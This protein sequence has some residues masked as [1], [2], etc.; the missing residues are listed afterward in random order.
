MRDDE[1]RVFMMSRC[2]GLVFALLAAG[3]ATSS[4]STRVTRAPAVALDPSK[5]IR[6]DVRM[7]CHD[8]WIGPSADEAAA[9]DRALAARPQDPKLRIPRAKR[10]KSCK[11][12]GWARK[13]TEMLTGAIEAELRELGYRIERKRGK[14]SVLY[15]DVRLYR[16]REIDEPEGSLVGGASMCTGGC[17]GRPCR[18]IDQGGYVSAKIGLSN[19]GRRAPGAIVYPVELKVYGSGM[20]FVETPARRVGSLT[21]PA[22]VQHATRRRLPMCSLRERRQAM[23]DERQHDW[24][25]AASMLPGE[26]AKQLPRTFAPYEETY[27]VELFE[28]ETAPN[29]AGFEAVAGGDWK[30]AL[31]A[32][33]LDRKQWVADGENDDREQAARL[34]NVAAA[35]MV[36]GQLGPARKT[37]IAGLRLTSLP[38][39]HDLADEIVRRIADSKKLRGR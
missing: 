18:E 39:S 21:L 38:A 25:H 29:R 26:L 28:S 19:T 16:I 3:C 23:H 34:H 36:L 1:P 27:R 33:E 24:D 2:L 4:F 32:F 14:S 31:D 22:I 37:I 30:R 10:E 11:G 7:V 17:G 8:F 20:A 5:A 35:Q 12:T 13:A 6:L 9:F 15:V